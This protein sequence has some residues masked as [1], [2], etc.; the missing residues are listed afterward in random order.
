[1][2]LAAAAV[3]GCN[4]PLLQPLLRLVPIAD[5]TQVVAQALVAVQTVLADWAVAVILIQVLAQQI[6][7][8]AVEELTVIQDAQAVQVFS[9]F[10]GLSK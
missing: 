6:Q 7:A 1:M 5:I 2:V 4:T 9:L 10:V 8:A 3:M